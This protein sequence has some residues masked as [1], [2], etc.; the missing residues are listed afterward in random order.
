MILYHHII[1]YSV[2]LYLNLHECSAFQNSKVPRHCALQPEFGSGRTTSKM[3]TAWHKRA[4]A[5]ARRARALSR[6]ESQVETRCSWSSIQWGFQWGFQWIPTDSNGFQRIPI[7]VWMPRVG[8]HRQL[9]LFQVYL[10]HPAEVFAGSQVGQVGLAACWG[11][12]A[13]D[14]A[15][16]E[17]SDYHTTTIIQPK[18]D[19]EWNLGLQ[20]FVWN[21][22]S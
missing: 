20:M 2:K 13:K 4:I 16:V 18:T 3:R 7:A 12:Q 15:N 19:M 21:N 9:S 22:W 14:L 11:I 5:S 10:A 8:G 6:H 1:S 17:E